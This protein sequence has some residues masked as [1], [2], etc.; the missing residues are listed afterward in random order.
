MTAD[1]KS[2]RLCKSGEKMLSVLDVLCRSGYHGFSATEISQET[3]LSLSDINTYVNTLV[4][5]GY[6]ER[7]SET[8]RI[9]PGMNKF[10]RLAMQIWQQVESA[11]SKLTE[12]KH[13]LTRV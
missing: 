9:R 1:K 12:I 7:I 3:G 13:N 5:T 4:R 10:A 11:N 6:A 2:E 8:G